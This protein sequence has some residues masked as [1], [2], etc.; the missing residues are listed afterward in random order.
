MRFEVEESAGFKVL[1]IGAHSAEPD[2]G[3]TCDPPVILVKQSWT[4]EQR[5]GQLQTRGIQGS[6]SVAVKFG[7]PSLA[8]NIDQQ[9]RP[10]EIGVSGGVDEGQMEL[11]AAFGNL[12]GDVRRHQ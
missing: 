2:S 1:H 6:E 8:R 3:V 5:E 4:T 7:G 11:A 9:S 10:F 12:A